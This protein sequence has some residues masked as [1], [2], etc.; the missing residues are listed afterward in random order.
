MLTGLQSDG[1]GNF[2]TARIADTAWTQGEVVGEMVVTNYVR[3]HA[4]VTNSAIA[5]SLKEEALGKA[6]MKQ[7]AKKKVANKENVVPQEE[8]MECAESQ[9]SYAELQ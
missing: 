5:L 2:T 8:A 7:A 6:V 4:R 3:F 9:F 1:A